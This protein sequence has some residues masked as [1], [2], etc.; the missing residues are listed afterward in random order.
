MHSRSNFLLNKGCGAMKKVAVILG[1]NIILNEVLLADS[2]FTRLRGLMFK[3]C[4]RE[5]QGMLI[6]PCDQIH[7]F[8]MKFPIDV[9]FINKNGIVQEIIEDMSAGRTSRFV[10]Q[11]GSV[12][13]MNA[14]LI[15]KHSI[16]IG[17]FVE[18]RKGGL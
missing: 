10:K 7:T 5:S 11:A 8:F 15:K 3:K 17:S 13:E 12:I 14:G 1:N 16:K 2:F 4:I 6:K 9:V 18:I